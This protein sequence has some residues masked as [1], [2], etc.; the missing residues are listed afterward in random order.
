MTGE[1]KL[2]KWER[3]EGYL[4]ARQESEGKLGVV[5]EFTV[6]EYATEQGISIPEASVDIQ[7]YL[8][9]QR[10]TRKTYRRRTKSVQ[11][12]VDNDMNEFVEKKSKETLF[13][14][15]RAEGTRTRKAV[16]LAGVRTRDARLLGRALSDDVR[17]KVLR[18]FRPDLLRL[19]DL[20]PRAAQQAE[21]QIESVVEHAL[22]I[23]ELAAQGGTTNDGD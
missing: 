5:S 13:V 2:T 23:L 9:Q 17:C 20:N 15:R 19:A 10:R 1:K 22:A 11:E 4:Y 16:W 8:S 14:I 12:L 21:A 18:A 6:Y 7:A 3:L